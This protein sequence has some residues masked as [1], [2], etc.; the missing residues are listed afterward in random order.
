[1]S[2][3]CVLPKSPVGP[4]R[5]GVETFQDVDTWDRRDHLEMLRWPTSD[6]NKQRTQPL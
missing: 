1:M 2:S 6:Q 5:Q 3:S 4:Q